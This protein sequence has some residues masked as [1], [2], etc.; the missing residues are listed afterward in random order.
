VCV[1]GGGGL[2]QTGPHRAQMC[3]NFINSLIFSD[4]SR[5]PVDSVCQF[6]FSLWVAIF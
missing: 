2:E 6:K 1:C 3:L 5:L 4:L